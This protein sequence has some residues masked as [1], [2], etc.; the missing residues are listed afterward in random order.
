MATYV[1]GD[2]QGC[3]K[4]LGALLDKCR[5]DADRDTLWFCGDL[6][7]RG[8]DNVGV[9]R[10][11]KGLGKSAASV[12]GN[13]ELHLIAADL[14]LRQLR[15]NDTLE[16]VL[17][18]PDRKELIAWVRARP[19]AF[20][21][22]GYLLVH[23]GIAPDWSIKRTLRIAEETETLLRDDP[24]GVIEAL[25]RAGEH[26][27]HPGRSKLRRAAAALATL[28]L[29]R[30]CEF[31]GTLLSGYSGPPA[32]TPAGALPW[33][34][35]RAAV[36]AKRGK[37]HSKTRILFGHWAAQGLLVRPD[38]VG[39]DTGCVWGGRLTAFRIEDERVFSVRARD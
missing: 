1:I 15:A 2:V 4:S 36:R 6:V 39:L 20:R 24:K 13:H 34:D 35:A 33:Y 21:K 22:R 29:M 16:D 18:A 10:F 23:A 25:V 7:N 32:D 27:Y 30:A 9:L 14:G 31:D 37:G 12:M 11:V 17:R 8:P 28:T 19:L 5:F 3:M 38:V 26:R